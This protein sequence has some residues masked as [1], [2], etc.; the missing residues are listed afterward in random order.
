MP[1]TVYL[2]QSIA[3]MAVF[4]GWG[5]GLAGRVGPAACLAISVAIFSLQ[6][7]ACHLWL[8]RYRFGPLEW[9]WRSLAYGRRQP[10]RARGA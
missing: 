1:L 10:M 3:A 2:S 7:A 8:R 4:Y 9:L 5:L 6:L